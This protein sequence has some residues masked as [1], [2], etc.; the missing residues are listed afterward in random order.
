MLTEN[1]F[2]KYLL[3]ASG[4]IV[5]VVIGILI[6]LQINN[7]NENQ[8]KEKQLDSIYTIIKQNLRTDLENIKIPIEFYEKL[9]STL[10]SVMTTYYRTS[11]L[12]SINENNYLD[13]I[14]C[15]SHH[16]T[17]ESFEM[18]DNGVKLLMSYEDG[19]PLEGSE[20]SQEIIQFYTKRAKQLSTINDFI[21]GKALSNVQSLEQFSWYCEYDLKKFNRDAIA[22]F[23]NDQDYKNKAATFRILTSR[24]YLRDLK[25]Y[26][27]SAIEIISKIEKRH[28]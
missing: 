5:L 10:L 18:Q 17:F 9:D 15:K 8:K 13:C 25:D 28:R 11:F 24:N 7:W 22:Y 26:E 4:E 19:E 16:H 2:G 27:I 12:D 20:L 21:A 3:Y 1:K 23:L 14:P 6:A